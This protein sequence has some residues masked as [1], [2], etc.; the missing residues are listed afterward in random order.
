MAI[1]YQEVKVCPDIHQQAKFYCQ[2]S[3]QKIN[4]PSIS[5]KYFQYHY[6]CLFILCDVFLDRLTNIYAVDIKQSRI[7]T[8]TFTNL[9]KLWTN[10]Q[11]WTRSW[12][13]FTSHLKCKTY[14]YPRCQCYKYVFM[15]LLYFVPPR[16]ISSNIHQYTMIIFSF[17][18]LYL[19]LPRAISSKSV[20]PFLEARFGGTSNQLAGGESPSSYCELYRG[21]RTGPEKRKTSRNEKTRHAMTTNDMQDISSKML[22]DISSKMSEGWFDLFD[23][24]LCHRQ[25]AQLRGINRSSKNFWPKN[26]C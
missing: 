18:L 15:C 12:G 11:V 3:T 17:I 20:H 26:R 4:Q 13:I 25:S 10:G 16:L 19:V 14:K 5:Y 24:R 9:D 8:K 21:H 23:P 6:H 22:Q 2:L 1:N 7:W